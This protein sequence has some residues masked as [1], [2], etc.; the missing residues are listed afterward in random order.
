MTLGS[1][2]LNVEL[3]L[4]PVAELA[5][6]PWHSYFGCRFAWSDRS[7]SL[8]RDV[9]LA[10]QHTTAKRLE[11][12]RFIEI[13]SGTTRTV[14]LCGGL[15]YH[16]RIG[17]RM[18]DTLLV[19]RGETP[20]HFRLAIGIDLPHPWMAA[21]DMFTPITMH[22]ESAAP[23]TPAR[24]GWLFHIDARN[25]VATSWEPLTHGPDAQPPAGVAAPSFNPEPTAT[26][27]VARVS[28]FRIRLYETEG[29]AGRVQL[30]CFRTP[31]SA[32]RTNFEH[33]PTGDLAIEDDR[34]ILDI[35]AYEWLEVEA[36]W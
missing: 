26:A 5:A 6:D 23:P 1:R 4:E 25:V 24:H 12:P 18:L 3:D 36:F 30:R 13:E 8:R 19:V 11:A 27:P 32:R 2:V 14:L 15:P 20:R 33:H 21:L 34:I 22:V 35:A 7:A 28:G 16:Q 9:H 17:Q 29:R 10:S 31:A